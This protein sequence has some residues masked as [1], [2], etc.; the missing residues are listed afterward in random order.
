MASSA[1]LRVELATRKR[2]HRLLLKE[3]ERCDDRPE[4]GNVAHYG[5]LQHQRRLAPV[6]NGFASL[7]CVGTSAEWSHDADAR[8]KG[9]RQ[10]L[11]PPSLIV[12]DVVFQEQFFAYL[13]RDFLENDLSHARVIETDFVRFTVDE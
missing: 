6:L 12:V 2:P 7:E 13:G 5:D 4:Q 11:L 9:R 10:E 1:A 3:V 8:V